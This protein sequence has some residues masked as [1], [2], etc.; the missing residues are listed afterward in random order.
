MGYFCLFWLFLFVLALLPIIKCLLR[1]LGNEKRR[2][3]V[4]ILTDSKE[5]REVC[6]R[7]ENLVVCVVCLYKIFLCFKK[8]NVEENMYLKLGLVYSRRASILSLE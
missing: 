8:K 4:K 5:Q 3:H 6:I 2:L 1:L 7:L